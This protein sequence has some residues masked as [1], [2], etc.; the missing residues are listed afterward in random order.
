MKNILADTDNLLILSSRMC[1]RTRMIS[2]IL[3]VFPCGLLHSNHESGSN[4]AG[5]RHPL[6]F[7]PPFSLT[8]A[9]N[10]PHVF[11]FFYLQFKIYFRDTWE[12][13]PAAIFFVFNACARTCSLIPFHIL[14]PV[15]PPHP[16]PAP[17][18]RDTSIS[19]S[20]SIFPGLDRGPEVGG[21]SP[22]D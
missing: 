14:H 22:T 15:S 20:S 18:T 19:S 7:A 1:G 16:T 13:H 11:L 9:S 6:L 4:R 17:P 2:C 3:S 8:G 10:M 12:M 21:P 5:L